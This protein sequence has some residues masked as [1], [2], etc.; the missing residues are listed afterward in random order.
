[1]SEHIRLTAVN[2]FRFSDWNLEGI[3]R[4]ALLILE[5]LDKILDLLQ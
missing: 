5:T 4:V 1:M 2:L 3:L